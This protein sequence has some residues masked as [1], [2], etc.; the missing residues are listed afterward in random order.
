MIYSEDLNKIKSLRAKENGRFA[1]MISN[2]KE[3]LIPFNIYL[4]NNKKS[5]FNAA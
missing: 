2:K 5:Y 1:H 3:T 4:Y